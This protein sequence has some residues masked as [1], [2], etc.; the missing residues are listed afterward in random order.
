MVLN[1]RLLYATIVSTLWGGRIKKFR[2]QIEE[3]KS[4]NLKSS[5]RI[6]KLSSKLSDEKNKLN[7][8]ELDLK[9]IL[10]K[11]DNLKIRIDSFKN[12]DFLGMIK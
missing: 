10:T 11:I 1:L 12:N 6:I 4:T 5:K 7:T 8:L 9:N 2:N 3:L